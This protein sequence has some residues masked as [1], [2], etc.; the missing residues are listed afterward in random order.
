MDVPAIIIIIIHINKHRRI[1]HQNYRQQQG[2][3]HEHQYHNAPIATPLLWIPQELPQSPHSVG[4][5]AVR[6]VDIL[7]EVGEHPKS[8]MREMKKA[9]K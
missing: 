2:Q 9:S 7:F 6:M 1:L 8:W 4:Q 5:F 3:Q